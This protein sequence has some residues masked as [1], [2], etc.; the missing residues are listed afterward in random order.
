M[1]GSLSPSHCSWDLQG[2]ASSQRTEGWVSL[3]PCL[4]HSAAAASC[5]A[6]YN[7]LTEALQS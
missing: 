7:R 2:G 3:T 5:S 1:Q 4:R 6:A